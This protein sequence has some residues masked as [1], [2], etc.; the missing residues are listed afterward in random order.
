MTHTSAAAERHRRQSSWLF[1]PSLIWSVVTAELLSYLG[2][3]KLIGASLCIYSV[4][5][6]TGCL[7]KTRNF[8][9]IFHVTKSKILPLS[10][11][12]RTAAAAAAKKY[13]TMQCKESEFPKP[14]LN[15]DSQLH[16]LDLWGPTNARQPGGAEEKR[17]CSSRFVFPVGVG[18]IFSPRR[19]HP[20]W[21]CESSTIAALWP[22]SASLCLS[23]IVSAVQY[24]HQKHIVHRDLKVSSKDAGQSSEKD[25][26]WTLPGMPPIV[27][28]QCWWTMRY[29]YFTLI[30]KW[31]GCPKYG[32]NHFLAVSL[33]RSFKLWIKY[34]SFLFLFLK[35]V[36]F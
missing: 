22:N 3:F 28:R 26:H 20:P 7:G 6:P 23:Q 33:L 17:V 8:S 36:I 14:S 5:W 34:S 16:E 31:N 10:A 18:H 29:K 19:P 21:P 9:F 35:K 15:N 12:N 24:C 30:W 32:K 4:E 25:A 2:L 1:S 13:S 27:Q 11:V